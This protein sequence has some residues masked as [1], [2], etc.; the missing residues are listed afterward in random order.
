[1]SAI[2]FKN[3]KCFYKSKKNLIT[4]LSDI[5]LEVDQGEFLVVVGE[6]GSGKSTM[7][8]ACLGL[9][10]LYDGDIFI[11]GE[12]IENINLKSGRFA[13]IRQEISLYP[14]LTVFENIAFPL[15]TMRTPQ[16]EVDKRV[17]EVA[18]LIGMEMFLNRKPKQL[19][20]GQQQR[21]A[22]ARALIKNPAFVFFDEPFSNVDVSLRSDLK[23]L[24]K[25]IHQQ[26]RPT[27][28]FVTHDLPEAFSLAD[29]IVV[30]ENG[31]IVEIGTPDELRENG[32]SGLI[33]AFL[34]NP[35]LD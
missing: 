14:N 5:N 18:G 28:I 3:F 7:L 34:G 29:R 10:E 11:D 4:A 27:I 20:G 22:I 19:S 24:V 35:L 15:R 31:E 21:V 13:F 30:L 9:A 2:F 26:I 12:P 17:R 25:K 6:S 16:A 32:K 33:R 23:K 8:K 1:M